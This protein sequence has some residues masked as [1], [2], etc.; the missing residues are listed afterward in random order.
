MNNKMKVFSTDEVLR[1]SRDKETILVDARPI[2]AY[3]GW[4]LQHE[5][6]GGH[7]QGAKSL[8]FKWTKYMDWIEIVRSKGIL[9]EKQI[10]IYLT[11]ASSVYPACNRVL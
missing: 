2:D 4:K 7:I 11:F 6:R 5:K 9:P 8:P 10:V 3:N 1:L